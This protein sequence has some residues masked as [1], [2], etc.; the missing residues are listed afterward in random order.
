MQ[1]NGQAASH[2]DAKD[3]GD[4]AEQMSP[5]PALAFGGRLLR[6]LMVGIAADEG[7]EEDA[8]GEQEGKES[9]DES[10]ALI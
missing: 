10:E 8:E 5:K 1:V 6:Q 4:S 7:D 3:E 9:R 2:Q